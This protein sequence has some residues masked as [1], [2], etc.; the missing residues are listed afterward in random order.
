MGQDQSL[1]PVRQFRRRLE[2]DLPVTQVILFGSQARG[3]ADKDSDWDVIIVSPAFQDVSFPDRIRR[4]SRYWEYGRGNPFEPLPYTP[5][6]FER[7]SQQPTIV[8][9]AL[10]EGCVI[11]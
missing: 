2:R 11:E 7:L 10:R 8:R 5:E 6:E 1:N 9:E 4:M 3:T